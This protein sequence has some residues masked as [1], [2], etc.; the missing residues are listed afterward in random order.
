M[1]LHIDLEGFDTPK[2]Y[3]VYARDHANP[4][5]VPSKEVMDG[6]GRFFGFPE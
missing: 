1:D 3:R 5:G 6:R 4:P 2:G